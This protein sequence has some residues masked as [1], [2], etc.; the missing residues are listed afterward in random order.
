MDKNGKKHRT[1]IVVLEILPLFPNK[2]KERKEKT[3]KEWSSIPNHLF[4]SMTSAAEI[5][6]PAIMKY[7]LERN[8]IIHV[9]EADYYLLVYY[10]IAT[11]EALSGVYGPHD[12]EKFKYVAHG[13]YRK[14]VCK[15]YNNEFNSGAVNAWCIW[16]KAMCLWFEGIKMK[17]HDQEKAGDKEATKG[18]TKDITQL[19][20]SYDMDRMCKNMITRTDG[21]KGPQEMVCDLARMELFMCHHGPIQWSKFFDKT[22][23][24]PADSKHPLVSFIEKRDTFATVK[25]K[26]IDY[27]PLKPW[28]GFKGQEAIAKNGK[29]TGTRIIWAT[30]KQD[31][32]GAGEAVGGE[33]CRPLFITL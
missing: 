8:I 28:L 1:E 13:I 29:N 3:N 2:I 26:G 33:P 7:A 23:N 14:Y 20:T 30:Q 6:W 4:C 17:C 10:F 19:Y 9:D 16:A 27:D 22:K 25:N 5:P 18:Y 32:T 15:L 24:L 12:P 21:K 11:F 31:K